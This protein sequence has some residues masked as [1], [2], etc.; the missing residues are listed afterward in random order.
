MNATAINSFRSDC[1]SNVC[2]PPWLRHPEVVSTSRLFGRPC[3][4]CAVKVA[5]PQDQERHKSKM[6]KPPPHKRTG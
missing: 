1:N 3:S 5:G 2:R 4:P 6:N